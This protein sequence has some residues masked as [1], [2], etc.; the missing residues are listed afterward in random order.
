[1]DILETREEY[2]KARR[3]GQK[4]VRDLRAQ[5][6]ETE[7]AVLD[8]IL[9]EGFT[10]KTVEIGTINVPA[11]RIVGTKTAGRTTAF[12]AGFLPLLGTETE[13]AQKW[14]NLCA[15][16][17]SDVGIRNPIICFEYLGD[18]YVQEGNKRV[19]VMKY[20]GATQI[21]GTVYR[22]LPAE[23]EE[24]R[25][26]AYYEFLDFYKVSGFYDILF[27]QPGDY[28]KLLSFLGKNPNQEWKEKERR[29]FF[30]V[31]FLQLFF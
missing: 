4:E 9:G 13:F 2:I 1:M 26:K 30:S 6:K 24:P 18:F 27:R 5:G 31:L 12:S 15:A 10:G 8:S 7:L 25:I 29:T 23:S 16:H 17:L 3:L 21:P 11:D 22:V 20:F 19:S 28:G 14:M